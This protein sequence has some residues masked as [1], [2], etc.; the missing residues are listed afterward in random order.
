M[1]K[2]SILLI[3]VM[4]ILLL[5]TSV[6]ADVAA[7][8]SILDFVSSSNGLNYYTL[9]LIAFYALCGIAFIVAMESIIKFFKRKKALKEKYAEV[10]DENITEYQKEKKS[11]TKK[12]V[13]GIIVALIFT[14]VGFTLMALSEANRYEYDLEDKKPIIYIYP[15]VETEVSVYL[16]YPQNITCSYPKYVDGW[17]V[18]A[19]PNGDLLDTKSGRKLY[20]LYWEGKNTVS[21]DTF[22]D[23]YCVKGENT[24]SFLEEKLAILGLNEREAEEFIVYWLPQLE[25]NAYNLIRFQ[26]SD[27][28]ENNMPLTVTPTPDTVIRVVMEWKGIAHYQEIS[29]Q[30]LVAPERTGFVVVEWGCTEISR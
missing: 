20:A 7:P 29:E 5:F 23:G 3:V 27:E 28:I 9:R 4:G 25:K 26:N 14:G 10:N 6:N 12:L 30:E 8:P 19:K 22:M 11:M 24:A 18:I 15:E 16:G 1:K 13:I 21:N 17:N 2:V